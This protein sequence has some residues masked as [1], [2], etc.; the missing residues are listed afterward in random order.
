[1]RISPFLSSVQYGREINWLDVEV[2][3]T[4]VKVTVKFSG[5]DI[6]IDVL[7]SKTIWLILVFIHLAFYFFILHCWFLT[8]FVRTLKS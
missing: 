8:A 4:K 5:G 2:K 7:P 3:R 1:V 6:T